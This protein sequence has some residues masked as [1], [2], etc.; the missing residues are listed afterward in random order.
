MLDTVNTNYTPKAAGETEYIRIE[1]DA[2]ESYTSTTFFAL[3]AKDEAGNLGDVSNIVSILVANGYRIQ[4]EGDVEK[5]NRTNKVFQFNA[6]EEPV[7]GKLEEEEEE[8]E[9][10]VE[11]KLEEE[12]EEE[13][14]PVEGKL[15]EEEE[16]EEGGEEE[17]KEEEKTTK[18]NMLGIG[19]SCAAVV[20]VIVIIV[21]A[22]I[23][24]KKRKQNFEITR[25]PEVRYSEQ[26]Q[27]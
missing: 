16:E 9:E 8:E 19:L 17:E 10:H 23:R 13:E 15:E 26:L 27:V 4:A 21:V 18:L 20:I 2:E 1:I 24:D 5:P 3:R 14:E 25:S 6:D 12:E 11:R 22:V 7:E